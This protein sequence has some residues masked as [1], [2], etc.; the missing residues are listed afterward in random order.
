MT[1]LRA[2]ARQVKC[3]IWQ[4][5]TKPMPQSGGRPSSPRTHPATTSSAT[6]SDGEAEY[7]PPF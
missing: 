6:E 4:P 1:A 3:A 7:P 2:A 5:V